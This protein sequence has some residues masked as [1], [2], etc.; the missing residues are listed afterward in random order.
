[1]ISVQKKELRAHIKHCRT[2][3]SAEQATEASERIAARIEQLAEFAE[4]RTVAL[5]WSLDGEVSTH[6]L[7]GRYASSKRIV[8][9]VVDGATMHFGVVAPDCSNLTEGAFGVM[10]PR[11]GE[12]CPPEEIELMVVPG[13]AF[14]REGGRLGHGKGYYDRYFELYKGPKV[15]ICFD[16]QMVE[17]VPCEEFDVRVDRVLTDE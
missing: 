8:L 9:P 16:Y 4:A 1:M 3:F 5:Y 17:S 14:D 11:D 12:V 2:T 15:G 10:E 6:D 13:V 7:V